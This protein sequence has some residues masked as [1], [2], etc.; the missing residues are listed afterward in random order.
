MRLDAGK[1]V[2]HAVGQEGS[3]DSASALHFRPSLR[4]CPCV[5][6]GFPQIKA[7]PQNAAW[8]VSISGPGSPNHL[9][10]SSCPSSSL[11]SIIQMSLLSGTSVWL[12]IS[13][14]TTCNIHFT[15]LFVSLFTMLWPKAISSDS[16][17]GLACTSATSKSPS[18][19]TCFCQTALAFLG[20][21]VQIVLFACGVCHLFPFTYISVFIQILGQC[22]PLKEH[23][24][25]F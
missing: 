20:A 3:H 5:F 11:I 12:R 19:I 21:F 18:H 14:Q 17:L 22:H 13:W 7:F 1:H 6:P 10:L 8:E 9:N 15:F 4:P 16:M 23:S 24:F 2:T 25:L